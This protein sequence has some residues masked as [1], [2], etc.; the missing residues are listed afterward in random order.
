MAYDRHCLSL[1]REE[2]DKKVQANEPYTIR[3]NVSARSGVCERDTIRHQKYLAY[4]SLCVNPPFETDPRR[5]NGG[6]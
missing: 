5:N 6:S 1:S 2:I 4:N 3:L